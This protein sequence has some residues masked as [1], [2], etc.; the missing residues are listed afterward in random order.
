[1]LRQVEPLAWQVVAVLHV[2][3]LL[4]LV[5][6]VALAARGRAAGLV[7]H[8]R[9]V[10]ELLA[11]SS[12]AARGRAGG[13]GQPWLSCWPSLAV[14]LLHLARIGGRCLPSC[15]APAE[16]LAH[17]SGAALGRAGG[18]GQRTW[19]VWPDG[20]TRP[21]CWPCR[22]SQCCTFV[23]RHLARIGGGARPKC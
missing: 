5:G 3:A 4:A 16:P 18:P 20:F 14:E 13:P 6:R 8:W 1:M 9:P 21:H 19:P 15:A 10:V 12:T 7:K 11:W 2:A 17:G 22:W 23:L